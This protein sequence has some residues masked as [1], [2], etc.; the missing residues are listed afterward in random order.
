MTKHVALV[1]GGS[2]GIGQ[3]I[4]RDLVEHDYEVVILDQHPPDVGRGATVVR[5]DVTSPDDNERAVATALDRHGALHLLVGNAG[6]HDGGVRLRDRPAADLGAL[7]RRVVEVDV[8][9]YVLAARASAEALTASHGS[10]VFTLSDAS[11]SVA[12]DL[13]A[14][15]AYAAAKHAALGIVRYLA[16][17]LAPDVRVNAVAPGGILTGLREADGTEIFTED[18]EVVRAEIRSLNPLGV[19]LSPAEVAPLYRFLASTAA[20][21][22]TGEVLRPDGGLSVR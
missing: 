21:G 22:M 14:G 9:G 4:V 7:V 10:M 8:L 3:A 12:P 19:V 13:G 20:A 2:S 5:G 15:I 1:T 18:P 11:F 6:I 17:D 16:A